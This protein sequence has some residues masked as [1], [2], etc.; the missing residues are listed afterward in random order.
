MKMKTQHMKNPI[1][2]ILLLFSLLCGLL[3]LIASCG[4]KENGDT[5][6]PDAGPSQAETGPDSEE[7]EQDMDSEETMLEIETAENENKTE[8]PTEQTVESDAPVP[9][10]EGTVE[11]YQLAPENQSLMMSYVIVTPNKKIVVI[12][13]G[14]DGYGKNSPSYLPS[15]IRAILG[16]GQKDYFEIEAWF[17]S[18]MHNDHYYELAKMLKRYK[19]SDNYKI[20]N[21]YFDF[22][23]YGVEWKSKAGDSDFEKVNFDI[24]V[25]GVD[26]YYETVGFR[27]IEGADI[28][29]DRWTAPD[30][31]EGY[32]YDLING[33]VINGET[34]EKGLTI[35]VDGVD[36]RILMTWWDGA[37]TVNN[38]SVIMKMEYRD[39]SVLFLGDCGEEEGRRL[40]EVRSAEEVK[41]DYIQLGHHG[42]GGP[43]QAFYDA[44]DAK[45]S[46]R[47]W[48]TPEWV[49]NNAQ[50]YAIGKTRS[51][52]G[53]PYEAEDFKKEKCFDTGKDFVAGCYKIY[54]KQGTKVECWT[55]RILSEQRVAVFGGP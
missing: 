33:A 5:D 27:G 17:F 53:L 22:P 54:P 50:S 18:H 3:C 9:E 48:P 42:Q 23:D 21:I 19:E 24:L 39:N 1:V 20:N 28:P 13:G 55:E 2:K 47:L 43:D 49:W 51:W 45:N 15:A 36:F 11:L 44:I 7:T 31:S 6:V 52:M 30:G 38:T 14:T 35:R 4:V 26:H 10:A 25:K 16:L 32:Y 46:I 29:E 41:S 8:S 37:S 40:L 12:D 34:V